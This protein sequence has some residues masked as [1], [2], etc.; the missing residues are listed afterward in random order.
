MGGA[1]SVEQAIWWIE[2]LR[3]HAWAKHTKPFCGEI[4]AVHDWNLKSLRAL[5]WRLNS[6]W[7]CRNTFYWP[8]Y[9]N[10]SFGADRSCQTNRRYDSKLFVFILIPHF[11]SIICMMLFL[12]FVGQGAI[13]LRD[14]RVSKIWAEDEKAQSAILCLSVCVRPF[15]PRQF[16]LCASNRLSWFGCYRND[17][18]CRNCTLWHK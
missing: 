8:R 3:D 4:P 13:Y 7:I 10:F 18:N 12:Y 9:A 14:D 15:S 16:R 11:Y 6:G 17:E 2:F 1:A 5:I